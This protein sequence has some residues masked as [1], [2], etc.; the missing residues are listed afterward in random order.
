MDMRIPIQIAAE[1]MRA[2]GT[3]IR[4]VAENLANAES[5]GA[6]PNDLPYRRQTVS[7]RAVM[8]RAL[9]AQKV[10]IAEVGTDPS[11]FSRRYMPGHPSADEEGYVQ[12]PNVSS[13]VEMMDLREAQRSYEANL[14]VITTARSMLMDTLDLLRS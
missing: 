1:G 9:G 6:T 2:Q 14:N 11:P 10:E 7:F 4:V 13:L 12:F 8:D 3:R 5:T